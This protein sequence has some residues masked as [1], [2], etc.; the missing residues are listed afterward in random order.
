M[1]SRR[2]PTNWPPITRALFGSELAVVKG[3]AANAGDIFL[4][5]TTDKSLG[6]Q[7]EGYLMEIG[8]SVSV[9]AETKTGAYWSTRTILQALRPVTVLS[10]RAP[11]A[12][13]RCIRCVV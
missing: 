11:P 5:K 4:S 12:I 3:G 13:I 9:K 1:S 10:R 6:L 8:G 2:P 7:D